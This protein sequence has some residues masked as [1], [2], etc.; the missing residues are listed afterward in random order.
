MGTKYQ[1]G[2]PSARKYTRARASWARGEKQATNWGC[3]PATTQPIGLCSIATPSAS[4]DGA[5]A[6]RTIAI[7]VRLIPFP[8]YL[9]A[10]RGR[11]GA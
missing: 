11:R 9:P 7:Q 4:A 5:N 8:P 3:L 6:D 1:C 2:L 10:L